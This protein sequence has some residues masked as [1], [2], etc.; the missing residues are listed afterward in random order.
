MRLQ[1]R[2]IKLRLARRIVLLLRRALVLHARSL[3]LNIAEQLIGGQVVDLFLRQLGAV[4][5]FLF[6]WFLLL[7][8]L[9]MLL[10][11]MVRLV[12]V[13]SAAVV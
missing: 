3:V 4:L 8:R 10:N 1:L 7:V 13:L 2:S 9:M 6:V 5:S 11:M 12:N